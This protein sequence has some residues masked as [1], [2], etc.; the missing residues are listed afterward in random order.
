MEGD[1]NHAVTV[2]H[3]KIAMARIGLGQSPQRWSY[4]RHQKKRCGTPSTDL[5]YRRGKLPGAVVGALVAGVYPLQSAQGQGGFA[6]G[7]GGMRR[8]R[9]CNLLELAGQLPASFPSPISF[10]WL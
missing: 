7:A 6:L 10:A 2:S 1:A 3:R 8:Q 5:P 9:P 4:P